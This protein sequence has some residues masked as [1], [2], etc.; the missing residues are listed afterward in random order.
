MVKR[1]NWQQQQKRENYIESS[2]SAGAGAGTGAGAGWPCQHNEPNGN[3]HP[4]MHANCPL[5]PESF[6]VLIEFEWLKPAKGRPLRARTGGL[7]QSSGI[8]AY[9]WCSWCHNLI[10][11]SSGLETEAGW[12][13]RQW[14]KWQTKKKKAKSA[15]L[16]GDTSWCDADSWCR[17]LAFYYLSQRENCSDWIRTWLKFC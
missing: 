3:T 9:Q 15:P 14:Q 2:G 11:A 7:Q 4:R 5:R 16:I 6:N 13:K 10:N 8:I 12:C 17:S 1:V